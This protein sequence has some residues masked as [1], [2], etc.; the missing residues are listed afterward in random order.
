MGGGTGKQAEYQYIL[1]CVDICSRWAIA[2]P[3]KEITSESVLR[4]LVWNVVGPYGLP[5]E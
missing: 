2:V 3:L 5:Q 1:T 4:A